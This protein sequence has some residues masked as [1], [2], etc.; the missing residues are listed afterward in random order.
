MWT[1][2]NTEASMA[3]SAEEARIARAKR[4]R[5]Q[6]DTTTKKPDKDEGAEK[7]GAPTNIRDK[8]HDR[9]RELDKKP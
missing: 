1:L 5:E 2:P 7:G 4:L 8:I 9:M 6:I 3:D